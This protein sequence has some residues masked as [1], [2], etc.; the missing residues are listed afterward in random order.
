MVMKSKVLAVVLAITLFAS[1]SGCGNTNSAETG[2]VAGS[3]SLSTSQSDIMA[4]SASET[5]DNTVSAIEN[6]STLEDITDNASKTE[7]MV[8]SDVETESAAEEEMKQKEEEEARQKAEEEARKRAEEEQQKAEEEARKKAEEEQ[9][10][11]EEEAR[12]KAEEEQ[13]KAEEEARKKAEEERLKAEEEARQ[14]AEEEARQQAEQEKI[15]AEQLNSFSM[16]Y[17]LAIVAEEIRTSKD[18]RL[19]LDDI[20]TALLND[21][22]PGAVDERTQEHLQNLRDIIKKYLSISVKRDRLQYIYNQDKAAAMKSAVPNPIAVLSMANSTDWKRLAVSV[23]YAVVDSYSSYKNASNEADKAFL[24]S[25]WE[26]DDEEV[27]AVQ[28][29]RDRAFD[30]MVDMVQEY[31]LDGL[32][33]LNE[34]AIERFAEICDI[35]S[36]PERISRLLSEEET[37][38][39]LGNYWLELADCYF[40]TEQYDKCLECVQRYNDL[41]IGIYRKDYNYVQILPKA[42]VAAQNTYSGSKYI[43]VTKDF[44]DAIMENTETEDWSTRYFTAQVYLDLYAKTKNQT[45]L[46]DAYDIAR[47]NVTI[48]LKGQRDLNATYIADVVEV[49]IDEPDYAYMDKKEKNEAK[50]EYN[51]EKKRVKAYNK[52]LKDAR[53]TELPSLYEPL[54]LNCELLFALADELDINTSERKNIE[55][56]LKTNTNGT[57]ITKP[58]NDAFSFSAKTPKYS[59]AFDKD[60]IGIP[61]ALLTARSEVRIE[62][63]ENGKTEKINDCTIKKVVRKGETLDTFTAY[64]ESKQLKKHKWTAASKVAVTICYTDAN[65]RT[66]SF[67]YKVTEYEPHWYGDKVVFGEA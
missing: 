29:N 40:Q 15:R 47:E 61:A 18:N 53:V 49:K 28:K 12:K 3:T 16:M 4:A 48:L 14:K 55:A 54:V 57:F 43:S 65:D 42:I 45:Y 27:A 32:K 31:D 11:A 20:Y 67:N 21:I 7:S 64:Y 44:A 26:L 46:K 5:T 41:S 24:M 30:Y 34:K 60:D 39:L 22:N 2:N 33:T 1:V 58:I 17:Y 23:V 6:D 37:Y 56:I 50:A 36:V 25:G 19:I 63:T 13:K 35:E 52:S 51:A 38:S 9:K 8:E 59:I 62:V 66:V 10:K